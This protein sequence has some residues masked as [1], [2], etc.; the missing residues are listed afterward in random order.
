MYKNTQEKK[1]KLKLESAHDILSTLIHKPVEVSRV[2]DPRE[3]R[4][5]EKQMSSIVAELLP[6]GPTNTQVP[7]VEYAYACYKDFRL[8]VTT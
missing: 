1:M 3:H 5:R 6:F 4:K 7:H 2:A 8:C